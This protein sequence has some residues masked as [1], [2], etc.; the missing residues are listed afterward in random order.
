MLIRYIILF[1]FVIISDCLSAQ[2]RPA[3]DMPFDEEESMVPD[4]VKRL[5]RNIAARVVAWNLKNHAPLSILW[6]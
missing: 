6:H 3:R 1:F 5:E 4:S 2:I